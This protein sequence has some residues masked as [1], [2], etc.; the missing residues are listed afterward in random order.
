MDD[1][2][3][4]KEKE[5]EAKGKGKENDKGKGKEKERDKGKGKEKERDEDVPRLVNASEDIR[6]YVPGPGATLATDEN[7]QLYIVDPANQKI[8]KGIA[9]PLIET[10]S[11]SAN[12]S[13]KA[14]V[15]I[16]SFF[17]SLR[18]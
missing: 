14:F 15:P 11:F 17:F 16:L 12:E 9:E 2:N 4:E 5:K 13:D 8:M 18:I 10:T 7:D 6:T 3:Y 1:W